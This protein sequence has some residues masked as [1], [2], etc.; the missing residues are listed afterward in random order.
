MTYHNPVLLFESVDGLAIV[1]DG[2]YVD[3]TFGGGGHSREILKCLGPE[4][5]L[6]AFDQDPEA[7]QNTIDDARFV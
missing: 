1:P 4:G 5:R 3:V 6:F 7:Q 2:I